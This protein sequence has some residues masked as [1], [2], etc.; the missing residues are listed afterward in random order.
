M[1]RGVLHI[2]FGAFCH[3]RSEDEIVQFA[4]VALED[5]VLGALPPFLAFVNKDNLLANLHY[6]VHIVRIDD[7]GDVVL[8]GDL[9]DEI[10]DYDRGHWVETR[11]RFVAE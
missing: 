11:V 5:V 6:R 3:S 8:L 1:V 2:G 10:I 7:C 4:V 9:F